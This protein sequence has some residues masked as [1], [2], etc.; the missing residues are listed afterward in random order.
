VV[1]N[2]AML[3]SCV[4][5][6]VQ[7]GYFALYPVGTEMHARSSHARGMQGTRLNHALS[8]SNDFEFRQESA[9][10][11]TSEYFVI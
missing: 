8:I 2:V 11:I 4:L 10:R 7:N 9:P 5:A 3:F 6:C 1:N